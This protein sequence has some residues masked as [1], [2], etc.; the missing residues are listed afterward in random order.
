MELENILIPSNMLLDEV[1]LSKFNN[2]EKSFCLY[3]VQEGE[4]DD[5]TSFY[6]VNNKNS[7]EIYKYKY[8]KPFLTIV[9]EHKEDI[10]NY[11]FGK[12]TDEHL[13]ATDIFIHGEHVSEVSIS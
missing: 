10:L 11:T 8:N 5:S 2:E 1:F 3:V 12:H 4:D 6:A 13:Y 7:E 9:K